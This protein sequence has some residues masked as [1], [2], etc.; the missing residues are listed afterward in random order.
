MLQLRKLVISFVLLFLLHQAFAQR[1]T[2]WFFGKQAAIGFQAN[3]APV[4]HAI[5]GSQMISS[6]ACSAISDKKDQ[7]L[8]YTN[9]VT[10]YNRNHQV[11][12]N[13]N[14]LAGHESSA[15][16]ALIV[17]MP[18]NDSLFYI[19]T[20]DAVENNFTNGYHYSIVN[21]KL[22]GGKGAVITKN[23]LL[24]SICTERLAAVR[25][26]N[27]VDVWILTNDA[28][29][30]IFRA[31]LLTCYGLSS[32]PVVSAVGDVMNQSDRM[33]IGNLK[34][35]SNGKKVCQT[36]FKDD[37]VSSQHNFFQ[38]FDFDDAT[39]K[40]SNP[41]HISLPSADAVA[42][43]FSPDSKLLYLTDPFR[44]QMSQVE[45]TLTTPAA[46]AASSLSIP[47][48]YGY[49][50]IQLGPDNKIYGNRSGSSLTVIQNPDKKGINCL[51]QEGAIDLGT[52][53]RLGLPSILKEQTESANDFALSTVDTCAGTVKFS[54]QTSLPNPQWQWDFG[55]GTFSNQQDPIHTFYPTNAIYT[56]EL[57]ISSSSSCGSVIK[58]K[59]VSPKGNLPRANFDFEIKC[60]SGYVKFVNTSTDADAVPFLWSFGDGS[61]STERNPVHAFPASGTYK[62]KLLINTHNACAN[63]SITKPLTVTVLNIRAAG[64][65]TILEGESVQINATANANSFKWTPATGL[66]NTDIS[67]PIATPYQ[68]TTYYVTATNGVDCIGVDSVKIEVNP[69]GDVYVPSAFSPN[70]DGLNDIFKPRV[71]IKFDL[72]NF[73]VYDRWGKL[74]FST[75]EKG[76]GWIG[77]FN[78]QLQPSGV[79]IWS[80]K[81]LNNQGK[82]ITKSG[83]VLLIR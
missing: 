77:K 63:D 76:K 65:K 58:Y 50:A 28:N 13:G 44:E 80:L 73:S 61:F 6:E 4:P 2:N 7:L 37:V 27:G 5:T 74:V 71:G 68:S 22:D 38:L 29:S 69:L 16:G 17:S 64:A 70:D 56:V 75:S 36:Y 19:F 82:Q 26:A 34:I 33:N 52:D 21:M 12:V 35:S 78:N 67:N 3:I 9:G 60:D 66:N 62:T 54:A 24:Q 83:T 51:L 1:Y 20:A 49:Y 40:L 45:C 10:V 41:Q 81:I 43:E 55:D 57:K 39:G 79:Y 46:I 8:F 47:S 31:W 32:N 15:Q 48:K 18:N 53:A 14:G 30:N 23:V 25:H 72:I 42:C 11:M 59:D